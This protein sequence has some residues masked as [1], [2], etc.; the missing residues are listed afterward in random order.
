ME[1]KELESK[2]EFQINNWIKG[3]KKKGNDGKQSC[4]KELIKKIRERMIEV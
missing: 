3:S 4:K 1:E 2:I